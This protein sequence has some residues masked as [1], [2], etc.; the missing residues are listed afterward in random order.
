M[1]SPII[2]PKKLQSPIRLR[3]L[4]FF[5]GIFLI[6]PLL[7]SEAPCKFISNVSNLRWSKF[8]L[9]STS[10][11]KG[12]N[13]LVAKNN[14]AWSWFIVVFV[15]KWLS[16]HVIEAVCVAFVRVF[17]KANSCWLALLRSRQI[18][19]F[20]DH[21]G[22]RK[23][24]FAAFLSRFDH[25]RDDTQRSCSAEIKRTVRFCEKGLYIVKDFWLVAEW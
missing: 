9:K 4:C 3:W 6:V 14:A 18:V 23:L 19:H 13:G 22:Q 20:C 2:I 5:S 10:L 1:G 15:E 16:F 11:L 21:V 7:T 12:I 25:Q 17:Q 8:V 24:L